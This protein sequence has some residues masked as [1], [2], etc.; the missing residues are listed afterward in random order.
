MRTTVELPDQQRQILHSI[1]MKKGLRGFSRVIQEA[2]D[3]FISHKKDLG[4]ERLQLLKL[5]GSWR[6]LSEKKTRKRIRQVR[7]NW[8]ILS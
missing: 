5:K 2:V 7:E 4:S 3:F 1:A 6:P 8:K